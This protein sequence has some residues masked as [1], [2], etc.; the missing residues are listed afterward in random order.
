MEI[1]HTPPTR[2]QYTPLSTHQSQTPSSFSAGPPILHHYSPSTT[3]LISSTDLKSTP[4]LAA[5]A[6]HTEPQTNGSAHAP[7]DDIPNP[8]DHETK[9]EG[10]DIWVTS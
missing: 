1:L 10:V 4:A 7:S 9:I 5:L 6:P 8:E 2:D 3:L